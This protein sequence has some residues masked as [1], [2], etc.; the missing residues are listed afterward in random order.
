MKDKVVIIGGSV[1]GT[2][3]M[4]ELVR[5]K[6]DGDITLID[7]K[8]VFPYNPYPLSKEWMMDVDDMN[9]PFIKKLE[10]YDKHN[11]N[12]KLNTKVASID[13]EGKVVTTD[14]NE[15]IPYN[16]LVIATGSKLRRVSL[17][18]DDASGIFYLREFKDA[19]A[20]KKWAK[21][22]ENV[23]IVGTGF[24]GLEFASTFTQMGKKVS[25]MVRSGRPLEKILGHELSEYF[26]HMHQ[27]HGVNFLFNEE[28]EE[29][30]KDD[31]GKLASILTK[32]GKE[33]KCDMAIIAVGVEPDSSLK[34]DSLKSERGA[35]IVN[36]FGETS[37]PNVY[38]GGD[39]VMWPYNGRMIHVE[40]WENAWSQGLSIAKNI[41]N[42]RSN[43]Y[44]V[45]PYF[46]T[47]QY[48]QTIEYLGNARSWNKI[49]IRGAMEDGQ[50]AVAYVDENNYPLAILFA[51]KFEERE[52]V[53]NLLNKKEPLD[54]SKFIDASIP[55][56]EI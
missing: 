42:E 29:F 38:A 19:L 49:F 28:T 33:I 40:H 31:S 26:T 53:E 43:A 5:N 36:E 35:I 41:M 22:A 4:S 27:S 8:E 11:I 14:D 13:W 2:Y 37:M 6:F 15:A 56:S 45:H 20:I 12:L 9:P 3:T 18:G 44:K 48:D 23:V 34:I 54:E 24:I 39:I 46:W 51:N 55:L 21:N 30:I 17:P 47:D 10:Y 25:V 52:D 1:T 7:R 50:F 32:S 16:H